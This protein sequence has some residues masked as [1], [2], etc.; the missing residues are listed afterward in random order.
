MSNSNGK[1][2]SSVENKSKPIDLPRKL[3]V[4]TAVTHKKPDLRTFN[5]Y[6]T[7]LRDAYDKGYANME[8]LTTGKVPIGWKRY[9]DK[10]VNKTVNKP[11]NKTVTIPYNEPNSQPTVQPTVQPLV[12]PIVVNNNQPPT[13][14]RPTVIPNQLNHDYQDPNRH[15]LDQSKLIQTTLD[16]YNVIDQEERERIRLLKIMRQ[17]RERIPIGSAKTTKRKRK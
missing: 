12:Q 15:R 16:Q 10:S 8:Y 11:V 13:S 17:P 7:L 2:A 4:E 5:K 6:V 1:R 14:N 9:D 3:K